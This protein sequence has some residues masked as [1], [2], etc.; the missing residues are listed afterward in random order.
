M[1]SNP[2]AADGIRLQKV[3]AAAGVGSRRR[4]EELISARRV[5]VDG[6]IAILGQRVDPNKAAIHVDG[7]RIPTAEGIVV[8]ALNKPEGV[9]STLSDPDGRPCVGDYVADRL[10]R[11][12]PV[13]RLDIDT[14]GLLLMTNDGE[15]S[16]RI[17]HPSYEM[18][19]TYLAWVPG[20]I[21]RELGR[22]LREGI[23]LEDGIA[24]V[25]SFKLVQ[26]QPGETLIEVVLHEGRNRIVRRMMEAAGFPIT[27]LVRKRVGPIV[28]GMQ[29]PGT[30]RV[31]HGDELAALYKAVGL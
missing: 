8:L 26:S 16:N 15:L 1:P 22:M 13:G 25:D 17:T 28:L 19:K 12:F 20:T 4:C 31:I 18:P 30:V 3:L 9:V 29:R 23:E 7:D 27:Q 6:K 5:T 10:E 24:R 11:I 14:N 21:P 2:A